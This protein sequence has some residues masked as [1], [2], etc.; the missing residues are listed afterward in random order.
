MRF[1]TIFAFLHTVISSILFLILLAIIF[2]P[3][4]I[5]LLIP[6]KRR[7]DNPVLFWI[8]SFFYWASL[9]IMLVPIKIKGEYGIPYDPAIII[10]NHESAL[11]IPLLGALMHGHPHI[12]LATN[13]LFKLPLFS[14]FLPRATVVVDIESPT[15]GMRSLLKAINLVKNRQ[16]H[17]VLF[18]EG[19]RY[20]DDH[21]HDF[22]SG[23]VLLAKKT[24]KPVIPVRLFNAGKVYPVHSNLMGWHTIT[25]VIGKP[26]TYQVDETDEQFKQ[27]V[28]QWFADQK[29]E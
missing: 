4:L 17:I 26:F 12:W 1:A 24:G 21:L 5:C 15:K 20:Q 10:A 27:R 13:H 28:F 7:F 19:G 2:I 25:V 11:D 22:Y 14:F 9:K 3:L 18:P 8:G 16:M 23:F 6:E 29:E